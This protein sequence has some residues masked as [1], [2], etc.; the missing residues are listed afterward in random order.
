MSPEIEEKEPA[1]EAES[2]QEPSEETLAEPTEEASSEEAEESAEEAAEPGPD[3]AFGDDE[4]TEIVCA[5]LFTSAAPLSPRKLARLVDKSGKLSD[6][7][8]E[9]ALEAL[10][11]RLTEARLPIRLQALGGGYR[12]LTDPDTADVVSQLLSGTKIE[13][14]SP[15][16]LETLAVVAYRQPV[17]KAEIEA[18][19]GVQAG[20][21]LRTLVDRDLIKVVGRADQPGS[22][23]QYGTT[24]EFLDR[25]GLS[26]TKD[27]PRDPEL[28]R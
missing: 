17:T 14:L 24:S 28:L 27:L 21:I 7:R 15:A 25:F 12:L 22:P 13:R 26:S 3:L 16:A 2:P 18:I 4:L 20:P 6:A 10:R 8:V 11:E 5:L 1:A 9:K 23:L 19:R